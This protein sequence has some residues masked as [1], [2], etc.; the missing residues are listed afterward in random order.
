MFKTTMLEFSAPIW[1]PNY[2]IH[3]NR[4]ESVQKQMVLF[5]LGDN[6]RHLTQSYELTP[7]HREVWTTWIDNTNQTRD[8]STQLSYSSYSSL[9]NINR[10]TFDR[11]LRLNAGTHVTRYP[12]FVKTGS[13]DKFTIQHCM[14]SIQYRSE[15]CWP[16]TST[17]SISLRIDWAS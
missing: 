10:H 2:I 4:I 12:S 5:L 11:C 15:T 14:R 6:Q 13:L 1:S 17:Q 7:L 3:R 16:D 8:A 9:S